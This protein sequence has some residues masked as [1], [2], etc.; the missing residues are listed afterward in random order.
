M[1]RQRL[2]RITNLVTRLL[3]Q[4]E[5]DGIFRNIKSRSRRY[6]IAKPHYGFIGVRS[7][8]ILA[9]EALEIME[10]TG[11]G[12]RRANVQPSLQ[13]VHAVDLRPLQFRR[14]FIAI[15][16]AAP[17]LVIGGHGMAVKVNNRC[18]TIQCWPWGCSSKVNLPG[19]RSLVQKENCC[20]AII[21]GTHQKPK[22]RIY[23]K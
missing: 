14:M 23:A 18:A 3:N 11:L 2:N 13:P 21:V 9:K 19:S 10:I 8:H 22:C 4:V 7:P 6:T 16:A 15:F 17:V 12:K 20:A 5:D 1:S